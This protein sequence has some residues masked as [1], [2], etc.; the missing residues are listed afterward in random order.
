MSSPG[1]PS[2]TP[3]YVPTTEDTRRRVDA[4]AIA[5]A[6][7]RTSSGRESTILGSRPRVQQD[8]TPRGTPTALTGGDLSSDTQARI[9]SLRGEISAFEAEAKARIDSGNP[10]GSSE[11]NEQ[12]QRQQ[13]LETLLR[14]EDERKYGVQTVQAFREAKER[15]YAGDLEKFSGA[16]I[17]TEARERQTAL[18]G[19]R[20]KARRATTVLGG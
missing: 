4:A 11:T 8:D 10:F 19:R 13:Q 1:R 3:T 14:G 7:R 9:D 20:S 2:S 12:A 5:E 15:G 16:D 18:T 6:R 17:T